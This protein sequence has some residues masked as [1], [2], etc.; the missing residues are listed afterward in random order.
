MKDDQ[1]LLDLF[2]ENEHKLHEYPSAD[3]WRRLEQRL[4]AHRRRRRI[5]FLRPVPLAASLV[6]ILG[7]AA[8]LTWVLRL[9][10]RGD[11][12]ATAQFA[13]LEELPPATGQDAY[14]Q[15]LSAYRPYANA[16]LKEG[17]SQKRFR[18]NQPKQTSLAPPPAFHNSISSFSEIT[19]L[20]VK[21]AASEAPA[22]PSAP[23]KEM[24]DV[25]T[26]S[27]EEAPQEKPFEWLV[28]VWQ[29]QDQYPEVYEEWT[30]LTMDRLKGVAYVLES[31]KRK[32]LEELEIRRIDGVWTYFTSTGEKVQEPPYQLDTILSNQAIFSNASKGPEEQL[33]LERT[34]ED[35]FSSNRSYKADDSMARKQQTG[36]NRS[37][38]KIGN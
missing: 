9:Q 14:S 19:S 12:Q 28:G 10:D 18:V 4:E 6:F 32:T 35:E 22:L 24:A 25:A 30:Y 34:G 7:T 38:K 23:V 26:L 13:V 2:R 37:M 1:K 33:I 11:A 21:P 31:G 20:E 8:L 36:S 17:D 16:A 29:S 27:R 5:A 3:A 15:S